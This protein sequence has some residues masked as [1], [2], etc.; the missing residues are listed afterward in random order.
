M[1]K[2]YSKFTLEDLS[3]LDIRVVESCVVD[4]NKVA[5]VELS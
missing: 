5:E 4:K 3:D 1:P 2:S